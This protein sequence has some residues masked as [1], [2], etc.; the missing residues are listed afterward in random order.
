MVILIDCGIALKEVPLTPGPEAVSGEAIRNLKEKNVGTK[1]KSHKQG[2]TSAE[3]LTIELPEG[4][5][6]PY[7][8]SD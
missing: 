5:E 8:R 4:R 3:N 7:Y 2:L 6:S 1:E